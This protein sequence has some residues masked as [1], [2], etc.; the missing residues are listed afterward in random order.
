MSAVVPS[1]VPSQAPQSIY[2]LS[3]S[4]S[5][6]VLQLDFDKKLGEWMIS[7]EGGGSGDAPGVDVL[8]LHGTCG[9]QA[10]RQPPTATTNGSHQQTD[11]IAS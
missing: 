11:S 9:L 6:S 5:K 1:V 4:R 8:V 3:P 2:R 10:P 7:V